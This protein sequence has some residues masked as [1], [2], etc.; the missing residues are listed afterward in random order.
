M[1]A[2][3]RPSS[4]AADA[5]LADDHVTMYLV[6]VK[7]VKVK[8]SCAREKI[9]TTMR[10]DAGNTSFF[11]LV[12]FLVFVFHFFFTLFC[13]VFFSCFFRFFFCFFFFFFFSIFPFFS[14][15]FS[16]SRWLGTPLLQRKNK[17]KKKKKRRKRCTV[18]PISQGEP[19]VKQYQPKSDHKDY[20]L[21]ENHSRLQQSGEERDP[22]QNNHQNSGDSKKE[23]AERIELEKF[24]NS[25][26]FVIWA[27]NFKIEVCSCY[28]SPAGAMVW[29][30][31]IDSAK[32]VDV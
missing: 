12:F 15:F 29:I 32:N 1:T 20:Q 24:P 16:L 26:P 27:M 30:N 13:F 14:P 4:T 5:P 11:F 17:K 9:E 21:Q 22:M 23:E 10:S 8:S 25:N 28:G 2:N 7:H 18:C 3:S 31:E 19:R 6:T